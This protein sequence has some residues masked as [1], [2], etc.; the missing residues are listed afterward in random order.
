M[1]S[2]CSERTPS[3]I[4]SGYALFIKLAQRC[5]SHPA[6]LS[7]FPLSLF[8]PYTLQPLTV[9]LTEANIAVLR[10]VVNAGEELLGSYC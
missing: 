8:S 5:T 9:S 1:E 6:P 4:S 10:S 2:R 3:A 7:M